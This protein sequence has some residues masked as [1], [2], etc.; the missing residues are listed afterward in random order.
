MSLAIN[1]I[2]DK[3]VSHAAALGLFDRV[4]AYEPKS[5]P[6][7]GITCAVWVDSLGPARATSGLAS[8]TT[9]LSFRV[10]LYTSMLSE[11]QDM[12]DPNLVAAVDTLCAAY[13]GDFT[14]GGVVR[15]VD[16]LGEVSDGLGA[17]AGYIEQDKRLMRI[18]DITL[19]LIV[20]DIW[21][22]SE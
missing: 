12:I 18:F 4:N 2:V 9:R 16:L 10:R 1:T 11:P 5:V 17:Q 13:S 6:G 20:N 21:T 19:P 7:S 8:T 15:N 22:Q 3:I 14:L